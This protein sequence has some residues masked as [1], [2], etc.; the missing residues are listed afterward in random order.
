MIALKAEGPRIAVIRIAMM[1]AGKA[2]MMSLPRITMSSSTEPRRAAAR[3]PRGTPATI[4][5]PT[6][7]TATAIEVRAPTISIDRM[8]RPK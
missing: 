4:P 5:I 6:A 7:T 2:K 1:S 8:S 3:S